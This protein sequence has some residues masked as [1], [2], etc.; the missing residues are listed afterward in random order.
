MLTL[1][2][3][4]PLHG[5]PGRLAFV[6][7]LGAGLAGWS[8]WPA[9]T[10]PTTPPSL[11]LGGKHADRLA[12]SGDES[13]I[14]VREARIYDTIAMFA[15]PR[16][17]PR[18]WSQAPVAATVQETGI[19]PAPLRASALPRLAA[20]DG[21]R[22]G[23]DAPAATKSA[24][25]AGPAKPTR[26]AAAEPARPTAKPGERA[27]GLQLFGWDLPG[28]RHLPTRRDA[29]QAL[30]KVG[31]SA[32]AVGSGTVRAVSHTAAILGDGV[33]SA[34]NALADKLGLN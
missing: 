5:V 12:F 28:S 14:P 11:A 17:E 23:P 25:A 22:R 13:E 21:T 19:K 6:L 30:D 34:G 31:S 20:N 1:R 29:A 24:E 10:V 15:Q 16:T 9:T 3:P 8:L 7:I 27:D 4:R 32:A 33:A 18:P 26:M 2:L